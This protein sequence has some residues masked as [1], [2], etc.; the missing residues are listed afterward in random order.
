[1]RACPDPVQLC[2]GKAYSPGV[3]PHMVQC[4]LSHRCS[5]T[6]A[7][8]TQTTMTSH[9]VTGLLKAGNALNEPFTFD[10]LDRSGSKCCCAPDGDSERSLR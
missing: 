7:Q 5:N 8:T 1:M 10:P 9:I 4:L 6:S 3:D 2:A